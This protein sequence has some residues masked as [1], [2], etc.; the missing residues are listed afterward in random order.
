VKFAFIAQ[1]SES[2]IPVRLMCHWLEVSPA[3]YYASLKRAP[4]KRAR[5]NAR[6]KL[7]IRAVYSANHRRYGA[8]KIHDE[9]RD[10]GISCGHNRVARLMREDG[11]RSKRPKPFRV[12]TRSDHREPVAPNLLQR[13]FSVSLEREI[14][15]AWVGDITYLYTREGW[16]YLS[17]VIDLSSRRVVAWQTSR[18]LD[19]TLAL[20]A[21][22]KALRTRRPKRGGM[23][24]HSDR[25]VQYACEAYQLALAFEGI[26]SSMS[27]KGDCWDNAVAE[28]FFATLKTELA[29]DARWETRSQAEREVAEY[30]DWYNHKRRHQTLGYLPPATYEIEMLKRKNA[31]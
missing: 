22:T 9:L 19:H 16:L 25:G 13:D 31:A 8:R 24:F 15:T 27:R 3:G 17:T 2:D 6:L 23:M 29:A 12:T 28:S 30:I 14:N 21:L 10:Q 20:E 26:R 1:Q 7:E 18:T 4:S 11:L 5:T